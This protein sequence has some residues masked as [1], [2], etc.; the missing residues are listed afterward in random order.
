VECDP[1]K[2][3]NEFNRLIAD[4]GRIVPEEYKAFIN[5]KQSIMKDGKISEKTKWLLML[6]SS[7]AQKCPVCIPRAVENCLR[8]GWSKEEIV[9]ASMVAVLIGGSSAMTYVTLALK[10]INELSSK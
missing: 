4:I 3:L 9:E 6:S 7:L 2:N 5:E 10:T 1:K 8:C